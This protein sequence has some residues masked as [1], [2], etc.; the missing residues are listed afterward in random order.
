MNERFLSKAKVK[1]N[2][3]NHF[4]G[5]WIEGYYTYSEYYN[6]HYITIE[7]PGNPSVY[8]TTIEINPSTL[9]Q[10]TGMKDKNK[11]LIFEG[12]WFSISHLNSVRYAGFYDSVY[13]IDWVAG[14]FK[15][16]EYSGTNI[17]NISF[18]DCDVNE[19]NSLC[20][21]RIEIKGN[22]YDKEPT[23]GE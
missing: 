13:I 9:C 23:E 3:Q 20:L 15:L 4:S 8:F 22:I 2:G 10:C 5:D 6:K 12:D 16:F 21:S 14:E 11:N 18:D 17:D 19:L 1:Y 7:V